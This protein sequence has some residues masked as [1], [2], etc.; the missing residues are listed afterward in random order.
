M[1]ATTPKDPSYPEWL[2]GAVK[3]QREFIQGLRPFPFDQP[4]DIT[5]FVALH[6]NDYLRL[7]SHP[8]VVKA[9]AEANARRRIESFSSAVF[10]GSSDEQDRFVAL[11]RE[12]LQCGDVLLTTAGWTANVGLLEAICKESTP[13]YIDM[14]AHAS[15]SDGVRLANARR[16]A[17]KHNDPDHLE[18]RVKIFG[19]GV[20]CIDALYSTDGTIPDLERYVAIC[21]RHSCVLVLDEAHS[22]GMFGEKGGGLAVE[23]G[24][25]QRVHFRTVSLSKAL[26]GHG[27]FIAASEEMIWNLRTRCRSVL[28]SSATS[29]VLAA[30]HRAGLEIVMREPQRARHALDMARLL[31]TELQAHGVDTKGSQSQIVSVFFQNEDACRFYGELRERRIL[32]SVFLY[33]AM[34]MGMSL[35]R[36]SMHSEMSREDTLYVAQQ[37]VEAL[38][39]MEYPL[40]KT[41]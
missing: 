7:S 18:K 33:P 40:V 34:P 31:V 41:G 1:N 30:G 21:E 11:L 28:F 8:E 12:S 35:A 4:A 37:T 39:R 29:A 19:P 13:V 26:G 5:P 14:E 36:F 27:G 6:Q 2:L 10:G 20:V 16:V 22:F 17:I 38:K 23:R 24:L 9:R 25:A 32:S 15:L 3:P